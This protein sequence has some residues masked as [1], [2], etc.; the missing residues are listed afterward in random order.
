MIKTVGA[1]VGAVIVILF[2]FTVA[3]KLVA[4]PEPANQGVARAR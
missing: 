2:M 3:S 1:A 4:Q